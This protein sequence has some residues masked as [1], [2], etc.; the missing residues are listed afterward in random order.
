MDRKIWEKTLRAQF[1]SF[2]VIF[3]IVIFTISITL[4][5]FTWY[6]VNNQLSLGLGSGSI[7][8][9]LQT[10]ALAQNLLSPGSPYGWTG[11]VDPANTATWNNVSIGLGVA[12]AS[13]NLSARKLYTFIAMADNNYQST[14]Q[15]V[16]VGYDYYITIVGSGLNITVGQNPSQNNALS[17]YVE[18]RSTF[19]NGNPVIMTVM[20]WTNT[21]LAIS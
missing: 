17:V 19:I 14:K 9:Q 15:L 21:P 16:G 5:A 12:P 13:S 3:S 2:D 6:N 10:H 18:R 4:L 1:W 20:V 11:I 7:I 8:A